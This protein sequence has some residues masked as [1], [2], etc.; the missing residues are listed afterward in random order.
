VNIEPK[1]LSQIFSES[2]IGDKISERSKSSESEQVKPG[3]LI[4]AESID[5][6]VEDAEAI[7]AQEA[8]TAGALG[9]IPRVLA[10]ATMPYS[11]THALEHTRSNGKITVRLVADPKYGLPYGHYPRILLAWITSEAVRTKNRWIDLG[12]NL[13]NFMA[14]LRLEPTGG[15]WGS[16]TRLR[17]HIDRLFGCSITSI[18]GEPG[19]L[20]QQKVI[21]IERSE[22]WWDAKHPEQGSLWHSTLTL[23]QTF[24]RMITE[25]P[26]PID[27]RVLRALALRRSPM[28]IDIYCWLTYR[29]SYLDKPTRMI[30]WQLL[31]QQMG[32][33]IERERDFRSKFLYW[34]KYVHT[35]YPHVRYEIVEPREGRNGN[36]GGL[37][38][39]PCRSSVLPMLP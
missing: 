35:L 1:P 14:Q 26:I 28:A 4:L 33:N 7:E 39:Y 25:R 32:S 34:L 21:P 13:S 22:L 6:L 24:F 37:I 15:R 9:F 3:Q 20:V 8:K 5:A 19:H 23:S 11:K 2:N 36:G 38:L 10:Q 27:L 29:V 17:D 30:P 18:E 12:D 31:Q 16:I